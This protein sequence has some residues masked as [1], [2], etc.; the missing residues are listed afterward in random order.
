MMLMLM[1]GVMGEMTIRVYY[2]TGIRKTHLYQERV[3]K[4]PGDEQTGH[5]EQHSG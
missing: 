4:Q 2:E 5:R 1:L 3:G